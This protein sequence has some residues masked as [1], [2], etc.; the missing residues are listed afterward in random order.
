MLFEDLV[1]RFYSFIIKIKLLHWKTNSFAVH[2]ST[3]QLLIAL[4]PNFDRIM[5]T[6]MGLKDEKVIEGNKAIKIVQVEDADYLKCL[7]EFETYLISISLS[8]SF[9]NIRDDI[10]SD[11]NVA[12]YLTNLK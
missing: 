1:C 12:K 10:L 11:I 7:S 2:K 3:D 4:E 8:E 5:E 6:Y 9:N